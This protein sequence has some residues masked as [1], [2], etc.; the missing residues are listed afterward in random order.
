MKMILDKI[1]VCGVLYKDILLK[2]KILFWLLAKT[3]VVIDQ[4]IFSVIKNVI[5]KYELC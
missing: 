4:F 1:N 2:I 5:F 3:Y